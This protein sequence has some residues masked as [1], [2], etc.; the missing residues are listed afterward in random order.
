MKLK[1]SL[2]RFLRLQTIVCFVFF[3]LAFLVSFSFVA[4]FLL[5][6]FPFGCSFIDV[7]VMFRFVFLFLSGR[8]CTAV[9][10]GVFSSDF[11]L[12]LL[13]AVIVF[14][15]SFFLSAGVWLYS[16]LCSILSFRLGSLTKVYFSSFDLYSG[17]NACLTVSLCLFGC[18]FI[19]FSEDS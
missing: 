4:S 19:G 18:I 2:L 5:S 1:I 16:C 17:F 15:V 8:G 10:D 13:H 12:A 11:L 14:L 9:D 3:L 7:G 6:F